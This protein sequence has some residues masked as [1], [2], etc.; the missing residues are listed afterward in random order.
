MR[1]VTIVVLWFLCAACSTDVHTRRS[2]D[3]ALPRPASAMGSHRSFGPPADSETA[4]D[5][6]GPMLR[7]DLSLEQAI[8]VAEESHPVM[9]AARARVEAA[10]GRALQAG[11]YPNPVGILRM[12]SAPFRGGTTGEAE[13]VAGV[14]LPLDV[15]GRTPAARRAAKLER[16]RA[17]EEAEATRAEIRVKIEGAFAVALYA[18]RALGVQ[19]TARELSAKGVAVTR[20]LLLAGE[21]MPEDLARAELDLV[22][23]DHEMQ[24]ARALHDLVGKQ[25]YRDAI[26]FCHIK[27]QQCEVKHFLWRP[28]SICC[29]GVISVRSPAH[30]HHVRLPRHCG[31]SSRW[32][33]ALH[34]DNNTW[35]FKHH[36]Q[37]NILQHQAQART[38]SCGH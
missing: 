5:P 12:E 1:I 22:R 26:T 34:I 29:N 24:R 25:K 32:R 14:S 9:A 27:C 20:A 23:A 38:R 11:L 36:S 2:S 28:G 17:A 7:H 19:A 18:E 21:A 16:D 4:A 35:D 33:A 31:Q 15:G 13:Y 8:A 6:A 3:P 37:T 10:E 30:L